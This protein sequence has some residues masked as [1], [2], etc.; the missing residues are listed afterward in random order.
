MRTAVLGLLGLVLAVAVGY[1]VHLITRETISL[2]VVQLE[3]PAQLAPAAATTDRKTTT[4][5]TTT[6][7]TTTAK[8][9]TAGTTTDDHGG[10]DSSGKGRGRGRSGGSD[11]D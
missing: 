3:Q 11:D 7:G 2:P 8:T 4:A 10:S 5:G 6:A 1:G 9:Q